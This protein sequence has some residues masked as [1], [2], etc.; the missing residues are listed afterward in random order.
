MGKRKKKTP[1]EEICDGYRQ[2]A[3]GTVQDAVALLFTGEEEII[4]KLPGYNLF[5]I[6]E[7][8]KPKGGGMEIKFFDRL[9]ALEKL[10]EFSETISSEPL[11]FYRALEEGAKSAAGTL[12]GDHGE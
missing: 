6:S 8:K 9:K 1:R 5:N 12:G 10:W 3:F 2:L 11:S 4:E 7:I